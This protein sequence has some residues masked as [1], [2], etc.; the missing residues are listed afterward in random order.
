M[1][2]A[3]VIRS[4]SDFMAKGMKAERKEKQE[5]RKKR[6]GRLLRKGFS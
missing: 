4:S 6:M 3:N 5:T 2:E 1:K